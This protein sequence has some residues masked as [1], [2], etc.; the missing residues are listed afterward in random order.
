MRKQPD[1]DAG[2]SAAP[3]RWPLGRQGLGGRGELVEG[4]SSK[5]HLDSLRELIECEPSLHQMRPQN[6][7][8]ALA[9]H[10]GR[11]RREVAHAP[12]LLLHPLG[13][14]LRDL[15]RSRADRDPTGLERFL[16][17]PGRAREI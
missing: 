13:H 16:L 8:G 11:A 2:R 6:V 14:H 15:G 4:A 10:V 7:H 12:R 17:S 5:G 3:A 9:I 1:R